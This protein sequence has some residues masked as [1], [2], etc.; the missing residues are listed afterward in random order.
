M[1]D[2]LSKQFGSIV[3]TLSKK[4][5]TEAQLKDVLQKIIDSLIEA[6]VP[7]ELA[8]SFVQQVKQEV[9]GKDL[10]KSLKPDQ[11]FIKIVHDKLKEFLGGSLSDCDLSKHSKVLVMGLQGSGKTTSIAK[12]AYQVRQAHP[13]LKVL[14]ASVDFCR[15]AAIDQLQI[16]A[17]KVSVDFYRSSFTD[18]R[19]AARDI[20]AYCQAQHYDLL[21]LDTAGR[22]HIDNALLE[23]LRE[24]KQIICPTVSILVLDAM[25]GQESLNVARAFEQAV[26]FNWG[27]LSKMDSDTRGGAAFSFR[28]ALRKP[29]AFVGT[30]EKPEDIGRFVPERMAGKILDMGDVVTLVEHAQKHIKQ[31]EQQS[32]YESMSAGKFT[33]E[34]FA[35]QMDMMGKLGSMSN[36]IKYLPG[37]GALNISQ[38][39]LQ[40]GEQEL[41]K[42]RAILSS[43]TKKE[44]NDPSLLNGSRKLRIAK[45][46]GLQVSDVNFLLSRFEES[47]Q[48]VKL[49]S[50]F[51]QRQGF[52]R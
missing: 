2:F 41:K 35:K 32:L 6:D 23:Q 19:N 10:I 5:I 37:A 29:I 22:L 45:G 46:A 14:L 51:G 17:H 20:D 15:P 13:Q 43:M 4:R 50:K 49:F 44:K 24:V 31:Q 33:L 1:F 27:M 11:Q 36:L 34:D 40:K 16:L 48:Y 9:I 42:C 47:K 26:G 39:A 3:S 38:E 12:L 18:A 30:G 8:E 7:H 25:T 21:L 52:F 28:Y